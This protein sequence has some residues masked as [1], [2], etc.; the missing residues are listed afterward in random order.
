MEEKRPK[1]ESQCPL[2]SKCRKD[3]LPAKER[4]VASVI[5]GEPGMGNVLK[6]K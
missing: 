5:G 3:E 6:S 4:G 1:N 2:T